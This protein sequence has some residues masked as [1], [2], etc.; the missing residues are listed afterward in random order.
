MVLILSY[1][2]ET[3]LYFEVTKPDIVTSLIS[4]LIPFFLISGHHVLS[5]SPLV[6][7]SMSHL[8]ETHITLPFIIYTAQAPVLVIG[9]CFSLSLPV[10][11]P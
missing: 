4:L 7:F 2:D 8:I 11:L 10:N 5:M 3:M 9:Q 1:L 6:Y